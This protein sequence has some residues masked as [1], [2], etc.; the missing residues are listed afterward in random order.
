[1][2]VGVHISELV[3]DGS[4]GS[5]SVPGSDV[6]DVSSS[7]GSGT[8]IFLWQTQE[9]ISKIKCFFFIGKHIN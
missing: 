6:Q 9:K 2:T 1:M 7:F 5:P 3:S 8:I 4:Y